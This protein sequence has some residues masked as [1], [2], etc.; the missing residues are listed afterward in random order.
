VISGSSGS[1]EGFQVVRPRSP[2]VINMFPALIYA[3]V[4]WRDGI[5]DAKTRLQPAQQK[6]KYLWSYNDLEVM[7]ATLASLAVQSYRDFELLLADDGSDQ[8]YAPVLQAWAPRFAYGILHATHEKRGF[9]KARILNRAIQASRFDRLIFLDMDCLPHGD[10]VKN[11]LTWLKPGTVITGRRSG[12]SRNVMP[13]PAAILQG[14]LGLGIT[15]LVRLWL[16]GKARA[17]ER[18]VV[19]PFFYESS[20]NDLIGCNFSVHRND[21]LAVNGF[22]E[23]F[24]GWGKEDTDLGL[25]LTFNNLRVRNLRNKV[26][27][28]H[29]MRATLPFHN[30]RNEE[31]LQRTI[32]ERMVRTRIGLAE[33]KNGDFTLARSG[34]DVGAGG[35]PALQASEPFS[36]SCRIFRKVSR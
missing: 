2:G 25:R 17:L 32:A 11:H 9:R 15:T 18:G 19:L 29:L 22:N 1:A 34:R 21:L 30:A 35:P 4:Q 14:G 31:L 28:Y 12:L 24:E 23:E 5:I 6:T 13:K 10:F 33:I 7:E 8:N 26:I 3:S 27:V 20:G 36:C 16:G